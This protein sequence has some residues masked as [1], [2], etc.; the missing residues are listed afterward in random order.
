MKKW[1]SDLIDELEGT[2]TEGVFTS[3]WTLIECYHSVGEKLRK[4]SMENKLK[5]TDLV[6]DCAVDLNVSERKLW[7]AVKFFDKFPD[8]NMLPE[9]KNVSWF[10]IKTKYLTEG[11]KK[12]ECVHEFGRFKIC[13][14]CGKREKL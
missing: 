3:R 4:A 8:V 12:I 1:Y 7:Y 5:I 9:G 11:E 6:S 13:L 2:I 10:G 14:K